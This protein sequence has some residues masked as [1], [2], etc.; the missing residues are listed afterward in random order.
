[1]RWRLKARLQNA[2][3]ALPFGSN[4]AYYAIQRTAGGLRRGLNLPMN[5]FRAAIGIA[6]W[7]E[8]A[9]AHV[10]DKRFLEVGTGHM[11]NVPTAL[12][13][14]G[15]AETVTVDLNPYLS[16]TLVEESNEFIRR[17]ERSVRDLFG[18]RS[19]TPIFQERLRQLLSFSGRLE[20]LLEMMHVKY[21]APANATGLPLEAHTIDFHVSNTVLEHIPPAELSRILAEARRVLHHEGMLVHRIDPSDHFSHDDDSIPAVNFLQ[22]TDAEWKRLAGNQFMYH[23]RL[24][25]ADYVELFERAGVHIL[26]LEGTVDQRSRLALLNGFRTA[27][28]FA[29]RAVDD[30][31]TT[32]LLLLGRFAEA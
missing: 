14:M 18:E 26:R 12:W 19:A 29:H 17:N 24:R 5:R 28:D 4:K 27:P 22:F 16:E 1:M 10:T 2:V 21:L 20:G 11:V 9:G 8:G 7:I 30:L 31:A 6:E 3:A 13:L 32:Q 25:S 23:N 15:A